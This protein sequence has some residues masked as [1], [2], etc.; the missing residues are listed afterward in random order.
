MAAFCG[1]ALLPDD[2]ARSQPSD[3]FRP[4]S[5]VDCWSLID[6][7]RKLVRS[8]GLL[9]SGHAMPYQPLDRAHSF[10]NVDLPRARGSAA[11]L[12]LDARTTRD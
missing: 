3:G 10:T 5:S 2:D 11:L 4:S 1:V 8:V 7:H 9:Q 12:V 6:P